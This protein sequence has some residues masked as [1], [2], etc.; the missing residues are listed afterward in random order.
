MK[1]MLKNLGAIK[2]AEFELGDLTIICG[3]N[4]TGKTYVTYALYG[5]LS[6]WREAFFLDVSDQAIETLLE[7][8]SVKIDLQDYLANAAK[9]LKKGCKDY[10]KQIP[11][12]FAS[13]AT[14]FSGTSF[15][16][17]LDKTDIQPISSFERTMGAAKRQ[18]F[19]IAKE[20]DDAKVT[21]TLLVE[22][23]QVK[24]PGR[25]IKNVIGDALKDIVFGHLL[26]KPF[27]ASAERT[28]AAIFRKE[29]NLTRNRLLEQIGGMDKELNPFEFLSKV[30][31]DYALPVKKN[32]EFTRQLEGLRTRESYIT[33]KHPELLN[34]ISDIIGGRYEVT[35]DDELYFIPNTN[36][37]LRL[38]M[39][40]SSSSVRSMLDIVFYL[41]HVAQKGDLLMVDE[42]ELN[43]HPE[44]QRRVARLFACLVNVGIN[45]FITTHSDYIVKELN[46]LIMMNKGCKAIQEIRKN[47][48]Y[49]QNE[50]ISSDKIRVYI[51]KEELLKFDG[52][53]RRTRALTLVSADIDPELGIEVGSFDDT[54]EEMNR[55]QELLYF[56][57]GN[58]E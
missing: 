33:Q 6:F 27:I 39:D 30:Y 36:K 31:S 52:M 55:I 1:I 7:E 56:V 8:G 29:L 40:E 16:L 17:T 13:A 41:R 45:V 20:K 54:I 10:I 12:V 47:E 37:R 19:S 9:I 48:K 28:G 22:K 35:R 18:L 51:A 38:T 50:T 25:M 42:P 15:S 44:N 23:K 46:T 32:I 43:L 14:H 11:M 2:Q 53:Q 21:I 3:K 24:I 57:E 5:F 34:L 58:A 26:P 49:E 4:N